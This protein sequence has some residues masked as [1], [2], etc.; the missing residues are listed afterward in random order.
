MFFVIIV[1]QFMSRKSKT[2]LICFIFIQFNYPERAIKV[3]FSKMLQSLEYPNQLCVL[4]ENL[5]V[6]FTRRDCVSKWLL[7]LL[8]DVESTAATAN[9]FSVITKKYRDEILGESEMNF[10]RRSGVYMC[11]KAMLQH[12]LTLHSAAGV[13]KILYKIIMLKFLVDSCAPYKKC[14]SFDIDLLSQM[15]AKLAR[16]IEKLADLMIPDDMTNLCDNVIANAKETIKI[17][18]EKIDA[19]IHKIRKQDENDA[20]LPRLTGLNFESDI[21]HKTPK[22]NEYLSNEDKN[23]LDTANGSEGMIVTYQ[24]YCFN[25]PLLDFECMEKSKSETE[26]RIFWTDF[27]RKVLYGLEI[28]DNRWTSDQLRSSS[29]AYAKYA[30]QNYK[31][32]QLFISR[33]LLVRLKLIAILDEKATKK[34]PLLRNHRSG[35]DPTIIENL[36]LPQH[37][38]M[39]I[40]FKLEKY[41]RDRNDE[42]VGPALIEETTVSNDSFSVKFAKEYPLMKEMRDKILDEDKKNRHQKQLEITECRQKVENLKSEASRLNCEYHTDCGWKVHSSWCKPCQLRLQA[43]QVRVMQYEHLLPEEDTKQFAIVFELNTPVAIANL[44]DVLS[45]FVQFCDEKSNKL[46]IKVSLKDKYA[47][48][49]NSNSNKVTLGSIINPNISYLSVDCRHVDFIIE[50]EFS[51]TFYGN[52]FTEISS[53]NTLVKGACT[54][55]AQDEYIGLQWTLNSTQHTENQVL[56]S[57]SKCG[58]DLTLSEYKNFGSLRADGHR[59]QIRKLYAM[60]ETEALSF[61]KESV[62][63]LIM[64]TLWECGVSGDG[65]SI[66]ESHIDFSDV[67][68][69]AAMIEQL[70]KFVKQQESNWMHPFKLL[71]ATLIAV[72]AFEINDSPILANKI[73]ILLSSIRSNALNWIDKIEASI[74]EMANPNET[75]ERNLRMKLIYVAIIGGLTFYVHR[76]HKYYQMIFQNTLERNESVTWLRFVISLKNNLR[77]YTNNEKELPSNLLMFLRLMESV[78]VSLEQEVTKLIEKKQLF[79]LIQ[80]QWPRAESAVCAGLHFDREHPHILVV[81]VNVVNRIYQTVTIDIITG[82]FLVD[83]LPLSRLPSEIMNSGIYRWFFGNVVFEV[84]PDAQGSFC[85]AQKY[86]K[87]SYEFKVKNGNIIITEKNAD[88]VEKELIDKS[89]FEDEFPHLLVNNYSHWWNKKENCI[90]FR[91]KTF[92]KKHFSKET[93]V[94]YRFN[95]NSRHLTHEQT[96]CSMLDIKSQSYEKIIKQLSRM[97]HPKYIHVLYL[98]GAHARVELLRMNLKFTVEC[99][100]NPEEHIL[101]SNEFNGMYVSS[102]QKIGTLYGLNH[103]LILKSINGDDRKILLIPNG[104][105]NIESNGI[106]SSVSIDTNIELQSPPFYQYRVDKFCKQLKSSNESYASW[107]YLAYLHAITAHGEVEPF[108]GMTGT[109]R[110]VQILHSAFAWSSSPYDTEAA[111]MFKK[112]VNLTPIRI[113]KENMQLVTWPENIP[114]RSAQDC[115]VF[116]VKKLLE[117]SQRL[118]GLYDEC[119]TIVIDLETNLM[120]NEHDH[121]RCQ[122]LNPNLRIS[123]TFIER[124]DLKTTRVHDSV[125]FCCD[126]RKVCILY[127]KQRYQVPAQLDLKGF[128]CGENTSSLGGLRNKNRIHGLLSHCIHDK[129]RNLWILLY[130][131]AVQRTFNDKQTAIILSFFAHRGEK[132]EPILALQ[133]VFANP[134]EFQHIQA[135]AHNSFQISAGTYESNVVRDLLNEYYT[136]PPEYNSIDWLISGKREKHDLTRTTIIDDLTLEITKSWPCNS[137]DFTRRWELEFEYIDFKSVNAAINDK[138]KTWYANHEL[139]IFIKRVETQLRSLRSFGTINVHPWHA[140]QPPMSKNWPRFSIDFGEK[141][142]ANLK[143]FPQDIEE[144]RNLWEMKTKNTARS[145][146]YWWKIYEKICDSDETRHLI[147]AGIFPRMVPSLL[148]PEIMDTEFNYDLKCLIG[149]FAMAI[150][151]EQRENRIE[152]YKR[153]PELKEKLD[154]EEQNIPYKNWIP[155]EFPEWLLF[156][157]EQNLTIRGIQIEIAK[158]MIEPKKQIETKHFVMQLNMGEGKTSVIVPIL[159]KFILEKKKLNIKKIF[160]INEK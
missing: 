93:T 97:E 124:K 14:T 96:Q 34:H 51:C 147:E 76:N 123:P 73:A 105:I 128:L 149:A 21:C 54:F 57:Q 56:S 109:E 111:E 65:N 66:R 99:P 39:F 134:N 145:S 140:L 61:E 130:D 16:R 117:D 92:E 138:L 89:I 110:A 126:T 43:K 82:S 71:T 135:P 47:K 94:D 25:S 1:N 148:L 4:S 55:N 159:G 132:I 154:K 32:N 129:F 139:N 41:F 107:F 11:V 150:A 8:M 91:Q 13:G 68:F 141:I 23:M 27:E 153:K 143:K 31:N 37:T 80:K 116:I 119:T 7:T 29:F 146:Q 12:S 108:I 59:L 3:K 72:R 88:N 81:Q 151:H 64:Q 100:K 63:A 6:E 152:A 44:R 30:E 122:Q 131:A 9:E 36:L 121:R 133:A 85:T 74:R 22:L 58:T 86:N 102:E 42:A 156:E 120:L 24:R 114:A 18:R 127:H 50:N 2:H 83:G 104:Q 125:S 20:Q 142:C 69:C 90:E 49:N 158:E 62:L 28:G 60:L 15:I 78:G 17:I 26:Q 112:I 155:R 77:M 160:I 70:E 118:R 87:C 75:T 67:K 84:Q 40:A 103:G 95:V 33:M 35:I 45:G 136:M 157:V 38:D 106:F 98:A 52:D 53:T 19:Q 101:V 113:M 5:P 137:V 46:K 144:A 48:Y 79:E 115:F 10:F